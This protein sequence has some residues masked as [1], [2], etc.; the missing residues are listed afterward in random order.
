MRY[1]TY[2][3]FLHP[4][5]PAQRLAHRSRGSPRAIGQR[6]HAEAQF[7]ARLGN[8]RGCMPQ[9][10]ADIHPFTRAS[11][12]VGS[13]RSDHDRR[14]IS[15]WRSMPR[16]PPFDARHREHLSRLGTAR[17][18]P[19]TSTPVGVKFVRSERSSFF[20][21]R[22]K[23]PPYVSRPANEVMNWPLYRLPPLV[24]IHVHGRPRLFPR[25]TY[26]F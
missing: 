22:L 8:I 13:N 20:P 3:N 18:G 12:A 4:N 5:P 21:A 1:T 17:R 7:P 6:C 9:P 2:S 23:G 24:E 10:A 14:L 15:L 16:R 25:G 11:L 26:L 19:I